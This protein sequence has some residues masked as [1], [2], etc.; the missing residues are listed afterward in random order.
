[1]Q[2]AKALGYGGG[3][4]IRGSYNA[5]KWRRRGAAVAATTTAKLAE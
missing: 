5:A 2:G 1:M 4:K 3:A